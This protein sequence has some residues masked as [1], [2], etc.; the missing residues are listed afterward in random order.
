[1]MEDTG[2]ENE[3]GIALSESKNDLDAI[4]QSMLG[5][6]E[7]LTLVCTYFPVS[8]F[9][10][11]TEQD[12][13]PV[14]ID[15]SSHANSD[16]SS[17]LPFGNVI[18]SDCEESDMDDTEGEL[19]DEENGLYPADQGSSSQTGNLGVEEVIIDKGMNQYGVNHRRRVA[20]TQTVSSEGSNSLSS[21]LD[22]IGWSSRGKSHHSRGL[23]KNQRKGFLYKF[24]SSNTDSAHH[25]KQS[26]RR[27]LDDEM[28]ARS[29]ASILMV[30]LFLIFFV[31]TNFV[32]VDDENEQQFHEH[33]TLPPER[34]YHAGMSHYLAAPG[35]P[36]QD[37]R[38]DHAVAYYESLP[39]DSRGRIIKPEV[40]L[41]PQ[42]D[43]VADPYDTDKVH[44]TPL[45]WVI[46]RSGS[47]AVMGSFAECN[48]L[49]VAAEFGAGEDLTSTELKVVAN[50]NIKYVNVETY[51]PA[52][53]VRAKQ[54]GLIPSKIAKLVA[55][56]LFLE[57]LDL[58]DMNNHARAFT[59]LR[60]PIDRAASMFEKFQTENPEMSKGMTIE[61]YAR[62]QYVEN[63]YLVRY[64]SGK[65]EGEVSK[66]ELI[67]AKEVLKKFVIGFYDDL[68]GAFYRFEHY[69][70]FVSGKGCKDKF[71]KKPYKKQQVKQGTEAWRLLQ[72]QN[73]LDIELYKYAKELYTKQGLKLF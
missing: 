72:W 67:I 66:E 30:S 6:F 43:F 62:S 59:V 70:D 26:S 64:L 15:E 13:D 25:Q 47:S 28:L 24:L 17:L 31:L 56:P 19:G 39:K 3:G 14:P 41:P 73:A 37:E 58:F 18:H 21:I 27:N 35:I 54:K 36:K 69:F 20:D 11:D 34:G 40:R 2:N 33:G 16:M 32:D 22:S 49:V 51:T 65:I 23:S 55:T 61:T 8:F 63:N 68:N 10:C 9:L 38:P 42:L 29:R 53:I 45:F 7:F 60:H 4:L 50:G 12:D 71:Q 46:P 52:G 5:K 44:D 48:S 1:M 57:S